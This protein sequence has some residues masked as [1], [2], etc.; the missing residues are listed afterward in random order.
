[1]K[2]LII[3]H[4]GDLESFE[5]DQNDVMKFLVKVISNLSFNILHNEHVLFIVILN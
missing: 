3:K 2:N 1:M 5:H 4:K